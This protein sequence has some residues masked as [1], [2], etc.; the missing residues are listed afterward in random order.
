M[1]YYSSTDVEWLD[2]AKEAK[3]FFDK[4]ATYRTWTRGPSGSKEAGE[5]FAI[6]SGIDGESVIVLEVGPYEPTFYHRDF[7]V[8]PGGE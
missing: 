2:F 7:L 5:L 4:N 8:E 1:K 6:R 3:K